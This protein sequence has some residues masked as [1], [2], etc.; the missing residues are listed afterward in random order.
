MT[1]CYRPTVE[2]FAQLPCRYT[3]LEMFDVFSLHVTVEEFV[4]ATNSSPGTF[5]QLAVPR[6]APDT[7]LTR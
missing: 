5:Q 6:T 7:F 1:C 2:A 3:L 4:A